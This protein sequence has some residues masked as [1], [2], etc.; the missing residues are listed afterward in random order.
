MG[1]KDNIIDV[2]GK[3]YM[4]VKTAAD[5]WDVSENAVKTYCE[6]EKVAGMIRIGKKKYYIPMNG[7]RPNFEEKETSKES[8]EDI[9]TYEDLETFMKGKEGKHSEYCH[10]A[11]LETIDKILNSKS[12]IMTQAINGLNDK[13]DQEQFVSGNY[14]ILCF[15]TGVN[16]NLP[17]WYMYSGYDGKGGRIRLTQKAA[18]EL[19]SKC[20]YNLCERIEISKNNYE[21]RDVLDDD[22][23]KIILKSGETMKFTMRDVLYYI[24]NGKVELQENGEKVKTVYI[25][26]NNSKKFHFSKEHFEKYCDKNPGFKKD[27]I[28]YYEKETRIIVEVLGKAKEIC[29]D[30]KNEDKTYGVRMTFSDDIFKTSLRVDFAPEISSVIEAVEK[31]ENIRAFLENVRHYKFSEYKGT[32]DMKFKCNGC[33]KTNKEVEDNEENH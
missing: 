33:N 5:F 6:N 11:S 19:E 20:E 23:K 32:V 22:G 29:C 15:S 2:N 7:K 12:F 27:I 16:E 4:D 1:K 31:N 14:F 21:W 3:K 8:L 18:C 17:M 25:K 28:W 9:K 10:Y 30:E 24:D 26:H 13:R